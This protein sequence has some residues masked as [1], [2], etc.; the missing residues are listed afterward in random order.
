MS[1]KLLITAILLITSFTFIFAGTTGKIAGRVT[2]AETGEALPGINI[3]VEGTTFGAAT[4]IDGK[5]VIN[6]LSPGT[7]NLLASGVGFQKKQFV[8]VKVRADFT[9]RLDFEMSIESI[10]TETVVVQA[11]TKMVKRDLT[12]SHVSIDAEQIESLPV[13]NISQLL[14]LQ[15]GIT[16]G[17]DGALHIRGGRSSEIGYSINGV[18]INN[19]Y[20]N[21]RGV[22]I[23]TN[24]I[25]ELA[26]V[27]GTFN[28]EYGNALSGIVNTV[29]KEGG[30]SYSGSASFYTGDYISSLDEM[31]VNIDDIDALNTTVGEATLGG[32]VPFLGKNFRF[33]GS[34]R[35]SKSKGYLYGIREH[36]TTDS[37]YIDPYDTDN[38]NIVSQG[39]G[40]FVAMNPSES[41]STTAKLTYSPLS[42]LKFN[43]DFIYSNGE[44][45]T[46]DHDNK[47][48]PDAAPTRYSESFLNIFEIRHVLS[49]ST[50]YTLRASYNLDDY[51][52]YLYPLLDADENT[53]DF[54]AG[55]SLSG[56]HA[57]PRY[58]P[59]Y[60]STTL[61]T[62][63]AFQN[64][65]TYYDGEQSQF[66][67][68]TQAFGAKI[69]LTSQLNNTHELKFGGQFRMYDVNYHYFTII[70]D[71]TNFTK[72]TIAPE[73]GNYHNNYVKKPYEFSVYIQ[74]KMEYENIIINIGL[75]YDFFAP[76]SQYSTN[77]TYPTPYM[78]GIPSYVDTTALLADG[79]IKQQLSPRIGISFPIT[80]QGII[81]FSY[82]H[83]IQLPSLA[84][85]YT[86]SDFKTSTGIPTFGNANLE[87]EK[88][89]SYELG[90]QQQLLENLAI[91]VTG[92]YKDVR[93]L[94]ARQRIRVDGD[95]SYNK[96]VNKDYANI[97]GF[98]FSL[99]KRRT[100]NDMFSFTLDYTYQVA[101]G[102]DTD[103]ESFFFDLSSGS[104][105]EKIPVYLDWDRSHQLNTTF[106]VGKSKDW[107]VSLIGKLGTGLPYTPEQY[108]KQIYLKVNSGR[109]PTTYSVDLMAE[110]T[111]DFYGFDLTGF[112]KIFNLFDTLNAKFVYASTGSAGYT[113]AASTSTAEAANRMAEINSAV[114]TADEYYTR[115]D[116][117][118]KPREVR[119]GFSI[120]F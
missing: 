66:Y 116:F 95:E 100:P 74:D 110:K 111:F 73:S 71:S 38:I 70:R 62:T 81:H 61:P 14:T 90:L 115:P 65:G 103:P 112:V 109:K 20:D 114:K 120:D 13:E 32:P 28:A 36:N 79:S 93:N 42:T 113:L 48:N 26:V 49:N 75:R 39:D 18:G 23:A 7:Y 41:I 21:S 89:V 98:V 45:K 106:T 53:V 94:L 78:S 83:F 57:D 17:A 19:P 10:T 63:I 12:S 46:Y 27:S 68:R 117:Y 91:N 34:G 86:N 88:T 119:F 105:I 30:N 92:F 15:A 51:K 6:N 11:E 101:E 82:G 9:T 33:F 31:F 4:D 40:K 59:D 8:D 69:D 24:A 76:K 50:F 1:K 47:Y 99:T 54:H 104:Q 96:Y 16:E 55:M 22:A 58:Q 2:D 108:D 77:R 118:S 85:L 56:F 29:T 5:F 72:A 52:R 80:D 84:Y 67:Q 37:V 3:L 97:K 64:G 102:N 25:Q 35:Y 60:K 107:N 87:P 43:Y 44:Y